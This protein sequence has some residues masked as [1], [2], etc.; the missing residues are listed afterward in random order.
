MRLVVF[1]FICMGSLLYLLSRV[2]FS[3]V[4]GFG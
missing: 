2:D 4:F 1:C 3:K